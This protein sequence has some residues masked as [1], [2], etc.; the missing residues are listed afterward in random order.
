MLLF[1]YLEIIIV[2]IKKIERLKGG[3][4]EM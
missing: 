2:I 4:V 1:Q 3:V